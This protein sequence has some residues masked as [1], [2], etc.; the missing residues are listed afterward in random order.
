MLQRSAT[1]LTPLH[2]ACRSDEGSF[3]IVDTLLSHADKSVLYDQDRRGCCPIHYAAAAGDADILADLILHGAAPSQQDAKGFLPVDYCH[4][5]NL[6]CL[7]LLLSPSSKQ[8]DEEKKD[9]WETRERLDG[10][11]T[12]QFNPGTGE[13][14]VQETSSCSGSSD[15]KLLQRFFHTAASLGLQRLLASQR[16]V[17]SSFA[18]GQAKARL[19]L[20]QGNERTK[21]SLMN[22]LSNR[23]ATISGLEEHLKRVVEGRNVDAARLEEA[24]RELAEARAAKQELGELEQRVA[25]QEEDIDRLTAGLHSE[26]DLRQQATTELVRVMNDL[27]SLQ[28]HLREKE[29]ISAEQEAQLRALEEDK[30]GLHA[31][32]ASSSAEIDAFE[33][34]IKELMRDSSITA[35]KLDDLEQELRAEQRLKLKAASKVDDLQTKLDSSQAEILSLRQAAAQHQSLLDEAR[36]EIERERQR[37]E[38]EEALRKQA[39]DRERQLREEAEKREKGMAFRLDAASGEMRGLQERLA[40]ERKQKQDTTAALEDVTRRLEAMRHGTKRSQEEMDSL[41][42]EKS[43]LGGQ[44]SA[45]NEQIS[46][47]DAQLGLAKSKLEEMKEEVERTR[48]RLAE[49]ERSR[50]EASAKVEA[51]EEKLRALEEARQL[52]D[53][54]HKMHHRQEEAKVASL[55]AERAELKRQLDEARAAKEAQAAMEK[56]AADRG[57]KAEA[58]SKE[59]EI[60]RRRLKE[61]QKWREEA[62]AALAQCKKTEL[63]QRKKVLMETKKEM[64]GV[65]SALEEE[66]KQAMQT[67][68]ELARVKQTADEHAKKTNEEKSRTQEELNRAKE[69]EENHRELRERLA[70]LEAAKQEMEGTFAYFTYKDAM[71]PVLSTRFDRS[72]D[73]DKLYEEYVEEQSLRKQYFNE[74]EDLKGRIRVFCR[75]RPPSKTAAQPEALDI[76]SATACMLREPGKNGRN[77]KE[78]VFSFDRCFSS[79]ASQAE[80]FDEAKRLVQSSVDGYNV[81][82]FAYGQSGVGKTYTLYSEDDGKGGEAG[83]AERSVTELFRLMDRHALRF[84]FQVSMYVLEIHRNELIDLLRPVDPNPPPQLTVHLDPQ[85]VVYVEN[86]TKSPIANADEAI[87]MLTDAA[88]KRK[89]VANEGAPHSSRSH[90]ICSLMIR[91][92]CKSSGNVANGKLTIVDLASSGNTDKLAAQGKDAKEA[93]A[94]NKSLLALGDVIQALTTGDGHVPYRNNLLTQLMADSIG[95]N[96][97]TLMFGKQFLPLDLNLSCF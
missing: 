40:Q 48:K 85:G 21:A 29:E 27:S 33:K 38:E 30:A 46:S 96:S 94:I 95:G 32:I 9:E 79:E 34:Q 4:P 24:L 42:A 51:L 17:A 74:I 93:K 31:R 8:E 72:V 19:H 61:E 59:N 39:A 65:K 3:A 26:Q 18:I 53:V 20:L 49:E 81:C 60:L 47:L 55:A 10:S 44:L 41:L 28:T 2:I 76:L 1:G 45:S 68:K 67:K 71:C 12:F 66:R 84:N 63:E 37:R 54:K 83:I 22:T 11:G 73:R 36:L 88:A 87:R 92:T 58:A 64:E 97:K 7:N 91:S 69:L 23:D 25:A 82:V 75:C 89:T 35:K 13:A 16:D 86:V 15:D 78:T 56:E 43:R 5:T 80:V 62:M 50:L 70:K 52:E 57:K 14:R 77:G 90:F 6:A